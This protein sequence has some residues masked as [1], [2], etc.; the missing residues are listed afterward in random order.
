LYDQITKKDYSGLYN[1]EYKK[2]RRCT[3]YLIFSIKGIMVNL[4]CL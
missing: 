1:P 4:I 3:V 2:F